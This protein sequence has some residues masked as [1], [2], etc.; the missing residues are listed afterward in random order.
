MPYT[1]A[2]H[3]VGDFP[4]WRRAFE[5]NSDAREEAGSRGGHIFRNDDDAGDVTVFL[6]WEDL[7]GARSYY[8]SDSVE[9]EWKEGDV[10]GEPEILYLEEMGRPNH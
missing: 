1:V 7:D 2:R 3:R 5:E 9:E 6:A 4:R 10:D 8:G